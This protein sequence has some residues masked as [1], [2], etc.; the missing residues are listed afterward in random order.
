MDLFKFS[1]KCIKESRSSSLG[2]NCN[3]PGNRHQCCRRKSVKKHL[4]ECANLG[5]NPA[6]W[7]Q[8][9]RTTTR[10]NNLDQLD[11]SVMPPIY[12]PGL[13][14]LVF[15]VFLFSCFFFCFVFFGL[16][17]IFVSSTQFD[18]TRTSKIQCIIIISNKKEKKMVSYFQWNRVLFLL[19]DDHLSRWSVQQ[20]RKTLVYCVNNWPEYQGEYHIYTYP[21]YE[22]VNY[23][24]T[25][26]KNGQRDKQAVIS[27]FNLSRAMALMKWRVAVYL[28][29]VQIKRRVRGKSSS[30]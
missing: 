19:S 25:F 2:S 5:M 29:F 23:R 30:F 16:Q 20:I 17:P 22:C 24:I 6:L 21:S 27:V 4:V 10:L 1:D 26:N 13:K 18:F 14:K 3:H 9:Q 8:S 11:W 15:V 12:V 7:L 28:E